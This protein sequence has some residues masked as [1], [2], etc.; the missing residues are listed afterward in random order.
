MTP[1]VLLTVGRD[2]K[3]F[4][5]HC[6]GEGQS[7]TLWEGNPRFSV[8]AP[9]VFSLASPLSTGHSSSKPDVISQLEREEKLCVK[10][11]HTQ[12]GRHSGENGAAR[13]LAGD[14]PLDLPASC[15]VQQPERPLE[16]LSPAASHL[17]QS[18]PGLLL[19]Q[20][21]TQR[22]PGAWKVL[23]YG[24]LPP[25]SPLI[26]RF[27]PVTSPSLCLPASRHSGASALGPFPLSPPAGTLP[28]GTRLTALAFSLA[29][30]CPKSFC[31]RPYPT[32]ASN[33]ISRPSPC[34]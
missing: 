9:F 34:P 18:L 22:V 24:L 7:L 17:L 28:A 16:S 11:I 5:N 1:S 19:L 29:P 2:G 21:K 32:T 31:P 23:W 10:E 27:S 14:G 8:L 26:L 4:G 33:A 3:V 25:A 30:V 6:C 12:R 13:V 15:V 20:N